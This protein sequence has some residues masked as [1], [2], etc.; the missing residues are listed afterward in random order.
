MRGSPVRVLVRAQALFNQIGHRFRRAVESYATRNEV[1]GDTMT[2]RL[3]GDDA[4][5]LRG[6]WNKPSEGGTESVPL[7]RQICGDE[8]GQCVDR[9]GV[10]RTVNIAQRQA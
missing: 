5:E 2:I 8:F 6:Y 7:D 9:F 1:S 4:A 3:S 10:V